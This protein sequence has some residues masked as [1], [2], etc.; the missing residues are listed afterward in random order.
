MRE[1][2]YFKPDFISVTYGAGGSLN[3]QT[4]IDIAHSVKHT[5]GIES[6]A[7]LPGINFDK[8]EMKKILHDLKCA[9]ID[10]VLA[11]RGDINPN[12][13]PKDDFRF[14]SELV[15]FY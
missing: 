6:V 1:L 8:T 13:K 3:G 5:Y 14:A 9:G 12:V 15:S 7:H 2:G 10:N 4:T 11:L